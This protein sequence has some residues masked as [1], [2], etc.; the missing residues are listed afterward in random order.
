MHDWV[1]GVALLHLNHMRSSKAFKSFYANV[2][3][4]RIAVD[5]MFTHPDWGFAYPDQDMHTALALLHPVHL[6]QVI[7]PHKYWTSIPL[8]ATVDLAT[9]IG[10]QV[11]FFTATLAAHSN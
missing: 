3:Y 9:D 8:F 1:A 2:T 11:W 6:L 10:G 5:R 7:G 4:A